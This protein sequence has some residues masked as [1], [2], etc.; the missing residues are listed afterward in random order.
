MENRWSAHLLPS[1]G[2]KGDLPGGRGDALLQ[3]Q[4]GRSIP[5]FPTGKQSLRSEFPW[6]SF[7]KSKRF[8]SLSHVR[9]FG[10]FYFPQKWKAPANLRLAQQSQVLS[11]S[12]AL[13]RKRKAPPTQKI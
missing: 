8:Q 9:G 4:D 5:A 3:N 11:L 6:V 1:E 2:Q 12:P 10:L 7:G 13:A